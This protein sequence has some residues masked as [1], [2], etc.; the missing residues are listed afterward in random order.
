MLA[1]LFE[2]ALNDSEQR[3]L[4]TSESDL[5]ERIAK[6]PSAIDVYSSLSPAS[7][8]KLIAEIKR[9]SPSKGFLADIPSA[10][11]LAKI[12]Q[13]SGA[14]A[15]SVLTERSGFGGSLDDLVAAR[16]AVEI[17]LLRKDFISTEYQILEARAA[18]ADFVLLILAH[19]NQGEFADLYEFAHS[20]GLGVLVET[21]TTTEIERAKD[22]GARLI[23]INTRNLENFQ[24]DLALYEKMAGLLPATAIKV[25]ESSVRNL[26]DVQRYRDAGADVVL[27]GEAL[28]TGEP[29]TLIPQFTSVA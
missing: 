6:L 27:V 28:V 9:R 5:L 19:L 4:Q 2:N 16:A 8:I 10:A 22:L 25:A 12:Y 17:P 14:H 15:I 13:D 20:L 11:E 1:G 29:S 7:N 26:L 3:K 21:H 24:T 23:G 18:G